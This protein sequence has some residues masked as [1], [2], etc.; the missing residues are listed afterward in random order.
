M[1]DKK[2]KAPSK[3]SKNSELTTSN[4]HE[5][6]LLDE[7]PLK[8]PADID[9][10]HLTL[11]ESS[12]QPGGTLESERELEA[13]TI[14]T[15]HLSLEEDSNLKPSNGPTED[16][17]Q[18]N[19]ETTEKSP[20]DEPQ[21]D[22]PAEKVK[23]SENLLFVK[24]PL[25]NNSPEQGVDPVSEK[26]SKYSEKKEGSDQIILSSGIP[27][28]EF[29]EERQPD[30]PASAPSEEPENIDAEHSEGPIKS[31]LDTVKKPEKIVRNAWSQSSARKYLIDNVESFRVKD[32]DHNME[33][34]IE[35]VYGGAVEKK[36]SPGKFLK[37][38]LLFSFLL[39]L[40]LFLAGWKAAGIFFPE[41]MPA[42]NDQI[43]ETVKN[44]ALGKQKTK[45]EGEKKPVVTNHANMKVINKTLSHCLIEP[46]ARMAFNS[47]FASVGYE[48]T[49]RS[50]TLSYDEVHDIIRVWK[51]MNM[52]FYISDAIFRFRELAKLALPVTQNANK[53][54]SDYSQSLLKIKQQAD[55]LENS[56]RNIKTS[57]GNQTTY[58]IN[59]RIPLR[60]KLNK[61]NTRLAEEPD[62]K[63]FDQLM[64]KIALVENI[65]SGREKPGRVEPDQLTEKDPEWLMSTSETA[66]ND[67]ATPIMGKTLPAIQMPADKLKKVFPKLTAF[68]LSELE[69]AL[70]DLLKLTALIIYLPENR[71]I[72]YKLELSGLNRRLNKTMKK[73]LSSWLNFDRCLAKERANVSATSK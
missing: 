9:T 69:N 11:D 47:A 13:P 64:K 60:N 35:K 39:F 27:D 62:Q 36:F 17:S 45:P 73:E 51:T 49:E 63:R 70:D 68:R 33:S 58:T 18:D 15:S 50:L 71:L 3:E 38:N 37:E 52:E 46:K 31:I 8:E 1:A 5:K 55:E 42:I 54:V 65:L 4:S 21:V 20:P 53:V 34:V 41:F 6:P 7:K 44:T 67:I 61:L 56:I 14:D 2:D 25:A 40:F 48:F 59:E 32:E 66:S 10:S 12:G 43:I 57:G 72:P 29:I 28:S 30:E 24:N 26:I 22:T 16:L 23:P 19:N